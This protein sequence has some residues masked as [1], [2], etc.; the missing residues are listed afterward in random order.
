MKHAALQ[1]VDSGDEDYA[2]AEQQLDKLV[3]MDMFLDAVGVDPKALPV[4]GA[5]VCMHL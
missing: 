4:R 3:S 2:S 5:S 1:G